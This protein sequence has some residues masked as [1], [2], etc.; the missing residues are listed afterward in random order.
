MAARK[1]GEILPG[2]DPALEVLAG[3]AGRDQD[4]TGMY[5]HRLSSPVQSSAS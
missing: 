1:L 2:D 3:L 5:L 4:V